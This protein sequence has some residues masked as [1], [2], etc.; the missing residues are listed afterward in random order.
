ML[1]F[2][3][4]HDQFVYLAWVLLF[5]RFKFKYHPE[6]CERKQEVTRKRLNNRLN[7]FIDLMDKGRFNSIFLDVDHSDE[8]VKIL[9]AGMWRNRSGY[10]NLY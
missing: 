5:F 2:P 4:Y 7:A 8:I 1:H 3:L 10:W 6:E 9:D